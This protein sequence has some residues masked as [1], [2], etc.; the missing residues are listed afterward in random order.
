VRYIFKSC[1]IALPNLNDYQRLK[2]KEIVL[3]KNPNKISKVSVCAVWVR[4]SI[5][6]LIKIKYKNSSKKSSTLEQL[7]TIVNE[8]LKINS[9]EVC[10][11][12]KSVSFKSLQGNDEGTF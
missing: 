1:I 12:E 6:L 5:C 3:K 4:T 8:L 7:I 10:P 9:T 2:K 11:A